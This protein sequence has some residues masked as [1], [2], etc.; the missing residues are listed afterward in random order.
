MPES[1][2]IMAATPESRHIMAATPQ[3]LY[4]RVASC[5]GLSAAKVVLAPPSP[6]VPQLLP[7][8]SV[9]YV[10]ATN[11]ISLHS[12]GQGI[13]VCLLSLKHG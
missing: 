7:L 9:L 8:S 5:R 10:M 13:A 12:I 2:H 1:H 11:S 3:S 6:V 4:P